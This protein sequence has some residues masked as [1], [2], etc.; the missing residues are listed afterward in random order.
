MS[1]LSKTEQSW[2]DSAAKV[3]EEMFPLTAQFK[4]DEL[5]D[6]RQ[7]LL[8]ENDWKVTLRRFVSCREELEADH[9]L[10]FYRLRCLLCAHLRLEGVSGYEL[11]NILRRDTLMKAL[12]RSDA[13]LV[14][15]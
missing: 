11:R 6:L 13:K 9:Y 8:S 2:R 14:E 12:L 3:V 10:P 5:L 1:S 15:V 7:S 4:W